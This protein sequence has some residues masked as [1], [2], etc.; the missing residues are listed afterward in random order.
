MNLESL[1]SY[2]IFKEELLSLELL[3]S[4]GFNN[5]SYLLKTSSNSYVIRVF[6]SNESV[7]ISREF[8]YEIQ[9]KAHK[10]NIAS[11]PIFLNENF[12]IY[13]YE[14]GIHKTKLSTNE[15]KN[16]VS[17]IK[18]FHNFKVKTKAYDLSFDLKNYSKKLSNQKSKKLIRKCHKS[19]KVLK[20]YKFEPVL[21]HHD[22]NPKNIIFNKKGFKIIDWEYA[23][24]NDRFFDL[25]CVCVEF[26][27][28]KNEEKILLN[29][30][31]QT[32]KSYHKIKLKHFKIIYDSFCKLWF[33]A[34]L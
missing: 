11:K 34:N 9:K 25:A 29:N 12:M 13:E 30:Y 31:F 33:E 6:K 19:I 32:K 17:K 4:Q 24:T 7:N 16:L 18:K 23:G 2:N 5:I 10:K 20:N 14:K 15:L 8:E 27:L 21:T 26:N 22:L 28:N 1:K 3:K